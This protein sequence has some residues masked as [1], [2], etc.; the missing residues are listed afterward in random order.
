VESVEGEGWSRT[1]ADQALEPLTVGGL[2]ANA[3]IQTEP[4]AVIPRQHVFGVVGLQEAVALKMPEDPGVDRVLEALQQLAGEGGGF[5]EAEAGFRIGRILNRV[6]LYLPE[7]PV[8]DAEVIVKV[9][10][11]A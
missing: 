7:E 8:H 1:I 4:S 5:V 6:T 2:D 11:E 3:S 9:R 10:I